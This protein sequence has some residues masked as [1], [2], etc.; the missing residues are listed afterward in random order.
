MLPYS[1][2]FPCVARFFLVVVL[3]FSSLRAKR[4]ICYLYVKTFLICC[5]LLYFLILGNVMFPA[6]PVFPDFVFKRKIRKMLYGNYYSTVVVYCRFLFLW[7][8]LFVLLLVLSLSSWL[9][10]V[11]VVSCQRR[12][13]CL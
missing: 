7:L 12:F 4:A 8:L 3:D 9:L 13:L 1:S 11:A 5:P 10:F 6:F 2:I